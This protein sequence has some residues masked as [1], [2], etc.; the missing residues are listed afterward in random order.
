MGVSKPYDHV[1]G[2]LNAT[3]VRPGSS[4]VCRGPT[5]PT[6]AVDWITFTSTSEAIVVEACQTSVKDGT[7]AELR[8][9]SSA[10]AGTR[11]A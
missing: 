11:H 4:F 8:S 3:G 5:L 9:E 1:G 7:A 6:K 2:I 10:E